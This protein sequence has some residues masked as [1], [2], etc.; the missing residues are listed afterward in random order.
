MRCLGKSQAAI[1]LLSH[2][3]IHA[4]CVFFIKNLSCVTTEARL[5]PPRAPWRQPATPGNAPSPAPPFR[6]CSCVQSGIRGRPP[7]EP[8]APPGRE[9]KPPFSPSRAHQILVHR[10]KPFARLA[11]PLEPLLMLVR[12]LYHIADPTNNRFSQ[13]IS[14]ATGCWGRPVSGAN[15]PA[16]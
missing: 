6:C 15:A 10:G 3:G 16:H 11:G 2:N 8:P 7:Q 9:D 12:V 1:C 14:T 4:R 13:V 5:L